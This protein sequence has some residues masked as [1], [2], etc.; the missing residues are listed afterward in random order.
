MTVAY[1]CNIALLDSGF[2]LS[3]D[4][5]LMKSI[6]RTPDILLTNIQRAPWAVNGAHPDRWGEKVNRFVD[7]PECLSL[8]A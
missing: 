3:Q 6:L 1:Y 5:P 7:Q 8:M 2:A 4:L